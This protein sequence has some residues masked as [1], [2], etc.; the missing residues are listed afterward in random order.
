M[1]IFYDYDMFHEFQQ[2]NNFRAR[3]TIINKYIYILLVS[4]LFLTLNGIVIEIVIMLILLIAFSISLV[5]SA[6]QLREVRT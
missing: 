3:W 5:L 1:P 4:F 2:L 6:I